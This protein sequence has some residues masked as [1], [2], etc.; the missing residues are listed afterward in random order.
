M[1]KL[2]TK[3]SKCYVSFDASARFGDQAAGK[4]AFLEIMTCSMQVMEKAFAGLEWVR[5]VS[6]ISSV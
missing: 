3:D 1:K 6:A 4:A 5:M 2:I